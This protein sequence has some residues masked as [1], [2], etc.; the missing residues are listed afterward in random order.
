M[1]VSERIAALRSL[2]AKQGIDA[3]MIPT[4]DNHQSEYVGEHFKARAFI[5]GF[6]GS[7]GTAVFTKDE[8]GMWTDGRYFIQATAQ[9]EGSGVTLRKMG[10]EGVPTVEEYL[11]ATLKSGMTLGFD[12][13]VVAMGTGKGLEEKL[14]KQNVKINDTADL[15]SEIWQDRPPLSQEKAFLLEEKYA[16]E[17]TAKKLASVRE[18]MKAAGANTHVLATLDDVCWLFNIRGNDIEYSPMVLSY[19]IIREAD[20]TLFVDENKLDEPIRKMLEENKVSIQPYNGVYEAARALGAADKVM[21]DPDRINYA[22]YNSIPAAVE[23][24]EMENPTVL[25]KAIKNETEIKNIKAAHI[26]DGVACTRFM[27]W[28][29]NNV[30]KE[31]MT[32][33]SAAEKLDS[34]RKEQEGYLWQSFEPICAYKEHAAMTHYSSTP[35]TDVEI[36]AEQLFLNDTGGNYYEGSTDITRTF[37]LGEISDEIRLHFTT[38]LRSM[39]GLARA[40]FLYGA[41]G[42]NLDILAR[43]PMWDLDLDYKHGTGHGVGYMLSIHEGPSG[44][45]WQIVPSKHETHPLEAGM[46]ITDEPGIYIE[47]SHGIRLENELL[48]CKGKE[49]EYGQFMYMEPVTFV[50][51]DLD[52]IDPTL[53][54]ED[55]KEY[56]NWYHQQVFEKISP[57]LNEEETQWLKQYTRAI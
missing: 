57:Y 39:I 53:L 15:I 24:I 32:E 40:R 46:V 3:Y 34:F 2:M 47:G 23:K 12:G 43:G 14:A 56:L 35:E 30:G 51:L 50:P 36:H 54:K 25:F 19:A 42:Y 27:Y 10:T 5:T 17:S 33:I 22:L 26:K 4:D 21:L 55:E 11:L 28:M 41:R 1:D 44:F 13:R 38:V 37:V 6:T 52:G 31:K 48:V 45:R 8:A 29:K 20:A 7:A 16:G 18:K 9:M 49:N